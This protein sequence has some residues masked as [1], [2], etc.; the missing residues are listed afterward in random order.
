MNGHNKNRRHG[1]EE[2]SE[3]KVLATQAWQP[4]ASPWNGREKL[5]SWCNALIPGPLCRDGREAL[6]P[7]M[8]EH[9]VAEAIN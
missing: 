9:S 7:G 1:W 5:D 6:S 8:P 2:G 4:E 3:R